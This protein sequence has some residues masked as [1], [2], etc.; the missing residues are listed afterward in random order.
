MLLINNIEKIEYLIVKCRDAFT[1][2]I[3]KF[4]ELFDVALKTEDLDAACENLERWLE[5]VTKRNHEFIAAARVYII[6]SLR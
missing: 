6:D 5:N 4:E 2:V 3:D 1:G